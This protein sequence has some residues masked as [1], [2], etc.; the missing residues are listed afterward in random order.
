MRNQFRLGPVLQSPTNLLE[1][2]FPCEDFLCHEEDEVE[3]AAHTLL[4]ACGSGVLSLIDPRLS[5]LL[6][7]LL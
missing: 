5:D 2:P 6:P 3:A 7:L 1:A 4:H